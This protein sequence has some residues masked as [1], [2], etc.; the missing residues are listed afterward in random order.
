[1]AG[2]Y[3]KRYTNNGSPKSQPAITVTAGK[4]RCV[5]VGFNSQGTISRITV[6]QTGGTPVA[7]TV[8][9]FD[10]QIPFPPGEYLSAA[11]PA[12]DLSLYRIM[13]PMTA[14]AGNAI[15]NLEDQF[16]FKYHNQDGGFTDN[17]RFIYLLIA[18]TS[19]G[20]MTTWDVVIAGEGAAG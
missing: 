1:M 17:Q 8:E 4:K 15:E 3:V 6:K 7:V 16:G 13:P 19:A 18:P 14:T 2:I 10:S 5:A 12:D 11:S 20:D 9:L